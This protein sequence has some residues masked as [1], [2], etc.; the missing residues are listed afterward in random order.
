MKNMIG[1]NEKH[2]EVKLS[3][4]LLPFIFPVFSWM[5]QRKVRA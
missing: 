1:L 2:D 4:I 5:R 3:F